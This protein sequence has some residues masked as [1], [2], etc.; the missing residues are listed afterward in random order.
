MQNSKQ[1]GAQESMQN[2]IQDGM[3]NSIQDDMQN[4]ACRMARRIARR[5]TCIVSSSSVEINIK[6]IQVCWIP[7][8]VIMI[9]VVV[10]V[11]QFGVLAMRVKW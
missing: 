3:L 7:S 10:V 9:V 8:Q 4:V 6:N 5:I 1:D 11:D 2:S